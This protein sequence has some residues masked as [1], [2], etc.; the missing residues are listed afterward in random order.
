MTHKSTQCHSV[1]RK[2]SIGVAMGMFVTAS[3]LGGQTAQAAGLPAAATVAPASV[4]VKGTVVDHQGEPVIG[5]TVMVRGSKIGTVTDAEGRYSLNVPA[6]ATLEVSFIGYQSKDV[7][8]R[9]GQVEYNIHL[10]EDSRDLDEVVVVGYG[11]QKKVNLTGSVT[12]IDVNKIAESRPI[13][14]ISQALAG[15]AP[16]V[17]VTS[18]SNKP[19]DD[20]AT[21]RVRGQGTLNNSSPLII[22]DGIE[23]SLSTISPDDIESMSIL[24]DAASS[25]IYGSRAANGVILVTTKKGSEGSLKVSYNGYVSFESIRKTL[26]P[27]SNYADY[28]TYLNEGYANSGLAQPFSADVIQEWRDNPNDPLKYPNSDWIDETFR[29]A[30]ATNHTLSMSGGNKKYRFYSSFGFLDNPGV[31]PNSG[32]KKYSTRINV[33]A[34]MKSWLSL[35]VNFN[36]YVNDREP[37]STSAVFD[38]AKATTPGM[39]YI[40]PDGRYG[41]VNNL[42]DDSQASANNPYVKTH[43]TEGNTRGNYARTRFQAVLRPFKGFTL[44]G[45]YTYA[46]S[47]SRSKKKPHFVQTWNFKDDYINYDSTNK[48]SVSMSDDQSQRYFNDLVARYKV[49]LVNNNL[50]LQVMAGVS[51]E[52]YRS[53]SLSASRQD[54]TDIDLFALSACTGDASTSGSTSEWSMTSYFGRI[55]LNWADKYLAEFNLRADGSSRFLKGK[56]WGYF[57]S[58]SI[59]WRMEQE[60]FMEPLVDKGLSNLKL[61]A[62]YGS[63][64]N[65]SVGNYEAQSTYAL[66]SYVL[67]GVKAPGMCIDAL[68]NPDLTWETTH[69]ANVGVDL[70]LF[71]NRLSVTAEYFHKRTENILISLPAPEVHGDATLPK[72]N[73][74][75][76]VNQGFELSATWSHN[77]ND[78]HYGVTANFSYIRNKVTKYKG[79][80]VDGRSVSS[81]KLTW[82]GH[83][84][85]C[86]YLLKVDRIIQ[87]DEDL[88]LINDI[89]EN[90]PIGADGKKVNPFAAFGTPQKGD[91]LYKDI[92]GDG[93]INNEDR[94]IVSD[95]TNPK[96]LIGV[97][98]N[99]SWKGIDFNMLIQSRLG[100]CT[101]FVEDGY[102]TSG[103]R[104]GYQLNKEVAEG[105]W[106]DGR[107]DATYPRLLEYQNKINKQACDFYLHKRDYVKIRNIQLGYTLP[108]KWMKACRIDRVRIYGT[109][110]NFITF[111]GYKGFDPEVNGMSY[112]TMRQAS[113][114][115]NLSF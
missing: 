85:D 42:E 110:E 11:Q 69:V 56:R 106:R 49:G 86:H 23:A 93:I 9:S 2:A 29:S 25:A 36:G 46:F 8:I 102:N 61:R 12:A 47:D 62:S 112:P 76:V 78:F 21:I 88:Q 58:G 51:H 28:M 70:G 43:T 77:I 67:N 92:N 96:Y 109:L 5:A 10:A 81:H 30:V 40:A 1:I 48:T 64:G 113:I 38:Y 17:A 18:S 114:G 22:I 34:D 57:P 15:L 99:A 82:E 71:N 54:L 87:T 32:Y 59:G 6:N 101:Y 37:G 91:F 100:G 89:I 104:Y 94:T 84:I 45:S 115:L 63:L 98:L 72:V 66:H 3:T 52:L 39:V 111:T 7:K 4:G 13:S 35:G 73:S 31:M 20:N 55:N 44:T 68:A 80:G 79:T 103:V 83:P 41:G 90:A 108:K 50:D 16:G 60:S 14:N 74:A 53:R 107:T 26:T 95:G 24:K 19:G 33:E 105:A 75:R 65:N 27:V 97:N